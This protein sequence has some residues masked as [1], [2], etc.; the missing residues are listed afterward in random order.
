MIV[1]RGILLLL[2]VPLLRT[3]AAAELREVREVHFQMGTFLEIALWHEEPT[4]ARRL[5]RNAVQESHRLE[6]I[7]SNYDPDSALSRLNRHAG[8]GNMPVPAELFDLLAR[9]RDL[10]AQSGGLFDVT[11]GP[12]M[13]LWQRAAQKNQI[14]T[15]RQRHRVLSL[16]NYRNLSLEHPQ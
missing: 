8:A 16:A 1:T 13:E 12:L 2:L 14:P 10:G 4:V 11:V 15:V 9:C 3:N 5:I 6:T 7:L